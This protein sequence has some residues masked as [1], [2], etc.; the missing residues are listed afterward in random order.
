MEI[1]FVVEWAEDA[2]VD[3]F[4]RAGVG[5]VICD[6]VNHQQL[7]QSQQLE[8]VGFHKYKSHTILR[9]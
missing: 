5:V 8:L 7:D 1:A 9:E 6:D 3:V 4:R 2:V